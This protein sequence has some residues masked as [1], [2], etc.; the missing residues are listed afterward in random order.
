MKNLKSILIGIALL[1]PT[2]SFA[3]PPELGKYPEVYEGSDYVITLLR[4]GEKEKKTVLIKVDGIDN[5]F[6]GQIYLHTKKCDN[7]PCTAFKYE[8]KEIPGK[9][10]WA[11][12]QTTSS[13]GSQ[14]NLIMYPPGINT[15]SSIYKV[16]RPKGFDSQ[17]FYDEYQGQKAIRKKSN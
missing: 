6:D 11:T 16:K 2:L 14:N 17:K 1:T 10:K 13:W 9:K 12:I 15:K 4:L 7:R 8:T 3:E 5:D